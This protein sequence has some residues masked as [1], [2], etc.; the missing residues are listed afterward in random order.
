MNM[1][2]PEAILISG[3][4]YR[5]TT[6]VSRSAIPVLQARTI[7]GKQLISGTIINM[8]TFNCQD[9]SEE[10]TTRNWV[11]KSSALGGRGLFA[12]KPIKSGSLIFSNKPLAVGPRADSSEKEFCTVCYDTSASCYPCEK[13]ALSVCS[14]D[15]VNSQ[16]HVK[17]CVFICQ[18]WKRKCNSADTKVQAEMLIYLRLLLLDE[19]QKQFLSVLQKNK[20]NLN[21]KIMETSC[22]LFITPEKHI[23]MIKAIDSIL[24]MNS[25]RISWNLK[26]NKTPL[27]GIYPIS[28]FLNHSCIPNT[29]NVFNRDYTMRVYASKDLEIG[30]E[31]LTCYTSILWCTPARRCQLFKTK[32]FWCQCERCKDPAEMGTR[33]SALKCFNRECVG[34]LLPLTP[35]DPISPWCCDN[36]NNITSPQQIASVQSMLGSLVGTLDLDDQFR[37]DTMILKRISRFIPY[38]NHIFVDLRLRLNLRI[39]FIGTHL[40]ELSESRLALKESLCRGTLRT[41]AALGAGDAHLRGLLLYHLHAALAERAR[42]SPDLYEDLKSEIE[43]TIKQAYMI[44]QD[45]ISAPPDLELRYQYLGPGCDKPHEER[46]FILAS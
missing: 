35:T 18:N 44:L 4:V 23:K 38:S 31:I 36:C 28:S 46:F 24:K 25:F 2:I 13:C 19:E 16:Q 27:R 32:Q 6:S 21:S 3:H 33:L 10:T 7:I 15:C 11:I 17:D 9:K 40:N 12:S 41:V 22:S 34:V 26:E 1:S 8:D 42:R 20:I 14:E 45:D 29:K 37:L 30:E 39:G 43:S 5:W